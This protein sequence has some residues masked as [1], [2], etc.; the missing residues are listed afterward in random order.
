MTHRTFTHKFN[1]VRQKKCRRVLQKCVEITIFHPRRNHA[2][3]SVGSDI[4]CDAKQGNDVVVY[5]SLPN[6][7][8]PAQFLVENYF[9]K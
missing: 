4:G 9:I 3:R 6:I 1:T 7:Y 5:E 2:H 8:F